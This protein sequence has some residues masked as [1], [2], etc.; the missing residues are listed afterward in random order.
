MIILI[1]IVFII[2]LLYYYQ[3]VIY[4]KTKLLNILLINLENR[5]N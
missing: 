5:M 3:S 2:K 1:Y 4:T